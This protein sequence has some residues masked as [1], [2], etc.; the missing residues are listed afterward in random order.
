MSSLVGGRR[1]YFGV[2]KIESKSNTLEFKPF[3]KWLMADKPN[4]IS[5]SPWLFQVLETIFRPLQLD[6]HISTDLLRFLYSLL[7]AFGQRILNLSLRHLL[8]WFLEICEDC[9]LCLVCL[10]L[11]LFFWSLS[12]SFFGSLIESVCLSTALKLWF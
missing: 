1:I 3:E 9:Q 11:S 12:I 6:W 7:M 2:S 10:C 4:R 5:A 8:W